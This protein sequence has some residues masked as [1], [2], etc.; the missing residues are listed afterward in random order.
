MDV[1]V[2]C[3]I[4]TRWK[5][6]LPLNNLRLH[7]LETSIVIA[8]IIGCRWVQ[9]VVMFALEN[10]SKHFKIT[11]QNNGKPKHNIIETQLCQLTQGKTIKVKIYCLAFLWCFW[12]LAVA[13]EFTTSREHKNSSPQTPPGEPGK[14]C[15][16]RNGITWEGKVRIILLMDIILGINLD[17]WWTW[18]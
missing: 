4:G 8:E 12:F 1:R 11:F 2:L 3:L 5:G 6:P 14:T 13:P 15:H 7:S 10:I 17:F 16:L 9:H 18:D